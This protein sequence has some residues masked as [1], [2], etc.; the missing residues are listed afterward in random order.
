MNCNYRV[1]SLSYDRKKDM[2]DL[3]SDMFITSSIKNNERII[4]CVC[5]QDEYNN[6]HHLTWEIFLRKECYADIIRR[7]CRLEKHMKLFFDMYLQNKYYKWWLQI[8]CRPP[9]FHSTNDTGG[10]LYN[11]IAKKYV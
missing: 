4:K 2:M 9:K 7:L 8:A 5:E 10:T 11:M 6:S 3:V 1:I